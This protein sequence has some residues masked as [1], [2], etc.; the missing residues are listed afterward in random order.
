M[1]ARPHDNVLLWDVVP[2]AMSLALLGGSALAIDWVLHLANLVWVGKWLGIPGV[3]LIVSSLYYSLR[4]RKIVTYGRPVELLKLHEGLAWAGS[5]LV[6]VHAGIH[7]N[8]W[9]AWL[10]TWAMLLNVCSGLTGKYLLQNVRKRFAATTARLQ[11]EGLSEV[12]CEDRTWAASMTLNIIKKWRV[13]HIP[14]ATAFCVLA[15]SHIGVEIWYW[16][17][18]L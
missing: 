7:F 4:K 13:V 17:F 16:G 6:L 5:L 11:A 18:R 3:L 14:I 12:D 8:A 9:L 1:H 15:L 2:F 10:A